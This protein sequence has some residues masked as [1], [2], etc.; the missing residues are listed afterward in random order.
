MPFAILALDNPECETLRTALRPQHLAYLDAHHGEILAGGALLNDLGQ[1]IGG[2][3][4]VDTQDRASA[5]AFVAGDPYTKGGVFGS[6]RVM[7]WRKSFFDRRR[8][9]SIS[10]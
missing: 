7:G 2:L 9:G 3:L 5:E 6:I 4:I 8:T 10:G 1:A